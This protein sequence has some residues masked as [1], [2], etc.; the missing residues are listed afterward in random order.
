IQLEMAAFRFLI[1]ARGDELRKKQIIS[2]VLQ[3]VSII[4]TLCLTALFVVS[5]FFDF[6][7]I[8][9]IV[10]NIGIAMFLNL[11]LQ[12]ARG[13]GENKKFAVASIISGIS[14][15]VGALTLI[16]ILKLGA[17]GML[18]SIAFANLVS[19]VYLFF[20][21]KLYRYIS[22]RDGDAGIKKDLIKYSAPLIPNG[23]SWWVISVSDRTIVS[24]FA[25]VAANGIYAVAN[26][27][28][29]IFSSIFAIFSMSWTES[30]SVHIDAKDRDRFL[31]DTTNASVKLFGSLGLFLIAFIP[32]VFS[33]L[34][35]KEFNEAYLYIPILVIAAFFNMMVG[36]YSAIYIAKKLT[37]QVASTSIVAAVI[38]IVINLVLIRYIGIYAAAIST[39]AAYLIMTIYRHHD[40]KKYVKITYDRYIFISLGI[41]CLPVVYLYYLNNLLGNLLNM[42]LVI[43]VI[44]VLNKTMI[45]VVKNKVLSADY[46]IKK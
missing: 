3:I 20:S 6:K 19:L 9:L 24:I 12:F 25:G 38:N 31:S 22:L 37:R 33:I 17:Q 43:M 10:L 34:V 14:M 27:Y 32:L 5:C 23:V 11:F 18:I 29:A 44:M 28:A 39:L 45:S 41:V 2:S 7:Y 13:F 4:F 40:V 15:A 21:L 16:A 1:D 36:L 8:N 35:S 26:K 42:L 46:S 30:V